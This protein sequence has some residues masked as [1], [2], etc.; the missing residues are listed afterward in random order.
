[1][2]ASC[3]YTT[4]RASLRGSPFSFRANIRDRGRPQTVQVPEKSKAAGIKLTLAAVVPDAEKCLRPIAGG[5]VDLWERR[6]THGETRL[7]ET[8]LDR[9][10]LGESSDRELVMRALH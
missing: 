8:A 2:R 1:M 3:S 5:L 10:R 4:V 9:H 7:L 6:Y